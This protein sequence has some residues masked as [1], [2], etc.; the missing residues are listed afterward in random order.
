MVGVVSTW[1]EARNMALR[2]AEKRLGFPIKK[3]WVDSIRLEP[4]ET[5][6]HWVVKLD[7]QVRKSLVRKSLIHISMEIDPSTGE[8]KSFQAKE[9]QP[10]QRVN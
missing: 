1:D 9:H 5:G 8:V 3:Y 2:E 7:L 6:S 4:E 10:A